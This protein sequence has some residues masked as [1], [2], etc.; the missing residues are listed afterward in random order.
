LQRLDERV[1]EQD[2]GV[3]RQAKEDPVA[4]RP[5]TLRGVGPLTATALSGALGG[6][7]ITGNIRFRA[8]RLATSRLRS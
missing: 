6:A 2:E 5:L 1:A 4:Q 3:A 7:H 8:R